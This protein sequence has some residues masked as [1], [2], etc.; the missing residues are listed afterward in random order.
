MDDSTL[1]SRNPMRQG[2][3]DPRTLSIAVIGDMVASRTLPTEQRRSAQ[4]EFARL[5]G[6]LNEE[7]SGSIAAK[8]A[9]TQ[10]DEFEGLLRV[11]AADSTLP[12]LI[13]RIEES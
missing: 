7:F 2:E 11:E 3:L 13:W 10:G 6:D 12:N 1:K 5:M 9:I 4:V 8:F